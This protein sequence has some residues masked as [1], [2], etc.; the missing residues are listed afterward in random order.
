MLYKVAVHEERG[1]P[2]N[3][4]GGWMVVPN[5]PCEGEPEPVND[6][7][8]INLGSGVNDGSSQAAP[9]LERHDIEIEKD[10]HIGDGEVNNL[11][12]SNRFD[13]SVVSGERPQQVQLRVGG[14]C[15]VYCLCRRYVESG[16]D[17]IQAR[18]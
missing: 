11:S 12:E 7:L 6:W 14:Q 10:L 17:M 8:E 13:V 15:G 9:R 5:I 3:G 2:G 18:C 16:A 1:G 4:E